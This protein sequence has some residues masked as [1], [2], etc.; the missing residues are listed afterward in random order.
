MINLTLRRVMM[1]ERETTQRDDLLMP[2]E[3]ALL[4]SG[5]IEQAARA[6]VSESVARLV[7]ALGLSNSASR[8]I[9]DGFR[10]LPLGTKHEVLASALEMVEKV[11]QLAAVVARRGAAALQAVK[12]DELMAQ[13][14]LTSPVVLSDTVA[15]E[16]EPVVVSDEQPMSV[17]P[18]P[19]VAEKVADK[20]AIVEAATE[21]LDDDQERPIE[22]NNRSLRYIQSIFGD[23]SSLDLREKHKSA[24]AHTIN[25]LRGEPSSNRRL[26]DVVPQL[27][28]MFAG[29]RD[30]EIG[31]QEHIQK[32]GTAVSVNMS[33]AARRIKE[34]AG[35]SIELAKAR[36][37]HNL[38]IELVHPVDSE[39]QPEDEAIAEEELSE[40][41]AS[42]EP[43]GI[44]LNDTPEVGRLRGEVRR[45]LKQNGQNHLVD[46][47]SDYLS[48]VV[49]DLLADE[50]VYR[51]AY[52]AYLHRGIRTVY[53]TDFSKL[54]HT[55]P[56]KIAAR[57]AMTVPVHHRHS[58]THDHTRPKVMATVSPLV[59]PR[60]RPQLVPVI[61]ET[62]IE[63]LEPQ[64]EIERSP[65]IR[66]AL[67]P[68]VMTD[69]EW[70]VEARRT[71]G[72]L[73]ESKQW[74]EGE[75]SLLWNMV[76]FDKKRLYKRHTPATE[77]VRRKLSMLMEEQGDDRL[78]NI[79]DIKASLA[80]LLNTSFGV[81][82]LDDIQ[83]SL[84]RKNPTIA[85][86][87]AQRYVVA[88]IYELTREA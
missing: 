79:R 44:E 86:G 43:T 38:G 22:L 14:E 46:L 62:A 84:R 66:A 82:N 48:R 2:E 35:Y 80:M 13:V 8:E 19:V 67:E 45:I 30:K 63:E 73:C 78:N 69:Q 71:L 68:E 26:A 60:Q 59:M 34:Q 42:A 5:G 3:T 21:Q 11:D 4:E 12:R 72:E 25:Q 1:P 65:L 7:G 16:S 77:E 41:E 31:A 32:S 24:I 23:V 57:V 85:D 58:D 88:G 54:I 55:M 76:H 39:V 20:P 81:K 27:L 52:I 50:E 64:Q 18:A 49:E 56:Q 36:L 83:Q 70:F 6:V 51:E 74:S 33:T 53:D 87:A 10:Q 15:D 17:E 47:N 61:T 40:Q 29:L 28:L 37:A 75:V 9:V